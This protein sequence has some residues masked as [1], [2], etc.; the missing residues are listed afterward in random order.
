LLCRE[1]EAELLAINS[2]AYYIAEDLGRGNEYA[3]PYITQLQ[4]YAEDIK[5]LVDLVDSLDKR[6]I[7]TNPFYSF[8]EG[9]KYSL[10]DTY[11]YATLVLEARKP[12]PDYDMLKKKVVPELKRVVG[13]MEDAIKR[14]SRI[15]KI[16]LVELKV[17]RTHLA[18]ALELAGE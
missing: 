8:V 17:A 13:N 15:E 6:V 10:L 14:R 12:N 18:S 7:Q 3:I 9:L 11:A 1:Q 2:A 5:R 4:E 16:D